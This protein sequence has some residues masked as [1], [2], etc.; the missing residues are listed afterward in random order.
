MRDNPGNLFGVL[1]C[2]IYPLACLSVGYLLGWRKWVP[3]WI[4]KVTR[5]WDH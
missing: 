1:V 2:C 5:L 4:H 3:R